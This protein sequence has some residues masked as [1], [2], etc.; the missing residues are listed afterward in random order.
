MMKKLIQSS[1]PK[2]VY[3]SPEVKE[4]FIVLQ[5]I[6]CTSGEL[7]EIPEEDADIDWEF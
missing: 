3:V 7:D 6:I 4:D 2:E 1:V 5:S